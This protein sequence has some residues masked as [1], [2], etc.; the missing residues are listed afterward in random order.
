MQ[1]NRINILFF[2]RLFIMISRYYILYLRISHVLPQLGL[3]NRLSGKLNIMSR[4]RALSIITLTSNTAQSM[5]YMYVHTY[6]I[7]H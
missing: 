6:N 3:I 4:Y 1:S 5:F 2:A 7:Y